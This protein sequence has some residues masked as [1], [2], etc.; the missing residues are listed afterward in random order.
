MIDLKSYDL[1]ELE[2]FCKDL[3]QPAFRDLFLDAQGCD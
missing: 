1:P 2:A 3:G